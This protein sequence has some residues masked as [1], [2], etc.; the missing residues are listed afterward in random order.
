VFA[1]LVPDFVGTSSPGHYDLRDVTTTF[2]EAHIDA[3][4]IVG[5][6]LRDV[7]FLGFRKQHSG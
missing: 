7:S 4:Y 6:Q 3:D 5:S 2:S 1:D